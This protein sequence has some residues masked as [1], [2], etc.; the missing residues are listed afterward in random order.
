P[1]LVPSLPE[2]IQGHEDKANTAARHLVEALLSAG[3]DTFFGVPG[4]P[5]MP[6]FDALLRDRR[7]RLVEARQESNAAFAAAGYS[8]ATGKAAAVVATAGPG[9]TN[10][11]TGVVSAHLERIPMLIICGDVAWSSTG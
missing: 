10:V 6:L 8:R 2:V 9:A 5:I 11:T 1:R 4:G 7:V 3:V